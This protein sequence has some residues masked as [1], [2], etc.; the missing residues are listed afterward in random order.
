MLP[1]LDSTWPA[2]VDLTWRKIA[3]FVVGTADC[4]HV[5]STLIDPCNDMEERFLILLLI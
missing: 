4:M 2:S 5:D 3:G 1:I